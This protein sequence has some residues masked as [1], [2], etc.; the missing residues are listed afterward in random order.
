MASTATKRIWY[1]NYLCGKAGPYPK[2]F[3]LIGDRPV[4]HPTVEAWAAFH[5]ALASTG[6]DAQ[7]VG[8]YNCRKIT[9]GSGYS[10][11]AYAIAV[12]IDPFSLGN[13]FYG[14]S[15]PKGWKFSWDETEFTREQVDAVLGIR[16]LTGKKVFMWGGFWTSIKDYMHWE[17]DVPPKD[18]EAGIDWSTVPEGEE[19]VL[20]DGSSGREV[21]EWQKMMRLGFNQNNGTWDPYEEPEGTVGVSLFD[22]QKFSP[23][24]DGVF[25]DT[26]TGNTKNVQAILNMAPTGIVTKALW[27]A[28]M[29]RVYGVPVSDPGMSQEDADKRYVRRGV[30]ETATFK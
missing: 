1:S 20:K 29:L 6:Y 27:D 10:L 22:G 12:D 17:I 11:H 3:I 21:A 26:A 16:T 13:P 9:G 14:R 28:V 18:L 5:Q 8:T 24:E 19:L 23:G 4:A 2:E 7:S 15:S 30:Q 25:G